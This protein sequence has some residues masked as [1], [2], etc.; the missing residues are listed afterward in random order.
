MSEENSSS[1]NEQG[2]VAADKV[3]GGIGKAAGVAGNAA[4]G[5][6]TVVTK[7]YGLALAA[8]GIFALFTLPSAWWAALLIIAYGIYLLLPGD[9]WVMW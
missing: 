2:W 1:G 9:K 3:L 5:C 4:V 6:T 7:L 8:A